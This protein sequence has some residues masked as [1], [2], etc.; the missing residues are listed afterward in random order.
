[1]NQ[2]VKARCSWRSTANRFTSRLFI[3]LHCIL[4]SSSA[5]HSQVIP[6]VGQPTT[7]FYNASGS[8][9]RVVW[10]LER[11][12]V[13]EDEEFVASLIVT[14][15]AN[16]RDIIR[17]DL[18]RLPP[19]ESR[20][21]IAETRDPPPAAGAME[22][23]FTYRLRP[24][25]RSVDRLPTL[26]FHYFNPAAANGKEFPL[27]TAREV[28]ITVAAPRLKPESPPIPL[29][30][31][32]WLLVYTPRPISLMRTAFSHSWAWGAVVLAG[33]LLALVWY[34]SWRRIYPDAVRRGASPVVRGTAGRRC[35]SARNRSL[36]PPSA[37]AAAVLGYLR[38]R[39]PLPPAAVTPTEISAALAEL[40]LPAVECESVCRFFLRQRRF[41]LRPH[42][43]QRN[44]AYGRRR[45]IDRAPG[46]RMSTA[47]VL[48]ALAVGPQGYILDTVTDDGLTSYAAYEFEQG[49]KWRDDA[50]KGADALPRRRTAVR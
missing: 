24:R 6:S 25:N 10:K 13:P 21:I 35:Y 48:F 44:V 9:V 47:V 46:G 20:F 4:L 41:P 32:E 1:M 23:R 12:S 49:M 17:P 34:A 29:S 22:V 33:P 18:R 3:S 14:G 40:G 38:A 42:Q 39:F 15:A 27:T 5:I 28:R 43:R 37:I 26:A 31:P 45:G 2:Q 8:H 50:V 36:D 11:T 7:D 16:P 30:E 19:F